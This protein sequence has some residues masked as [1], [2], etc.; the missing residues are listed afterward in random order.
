M[1]AKSFFI[2][3]QSLSTLCVPWLAGCGNPSISP[4]ERSYETAMRILRTPQHKKALDAI[5]EMDDVNALRIIAQTASSTAWPMEASPD[6][7]F[8][9]ILENI[10]LASIH[11]LH[12]IDSPE[13]RKSIEYC[14]RSLTIDGSVSLLLK[15]WEDEARDKREDEYVMIPQLDKA[16]QGKDGVK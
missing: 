10:S 3:A 15:K 16:P 6:M 4:K 7:H 11:R 8:D 14:K 1:T 9:N 2:I 12:I 5:A 13:A